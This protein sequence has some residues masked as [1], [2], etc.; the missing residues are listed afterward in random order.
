MFQILDESSLN[1]FTLTLNGEPLTRSGV[2][3][4]YLSFLIE[5]TDA[6]DVDIAVTMKDRYGNESMEEFTFTVTEEKVQLFAASADFDARLDA[7]YLMNMGETQNTTDI[8]EVFGDSTH[9]VNLSWDLNAETFL[10]AGP[11]SLELY[12]GLKD[13]VAAQD[14]LDSY[15]N[16]LIADMQNFLNLYNPIDLTR[17]FDYTG[18]E[19]RVY[20]NDN[21][22]YVRLFLFDPAISYTFGDQT[23]LYQKE[24]IKNM[25]MRGSSLSINLPFLE[26]Q[27]SKGLTDPGLY[28]VAW[29][30]N[31]LGF[32]FAVKAKEAWYLQTNLSII[33]SAQ[34]T[35]DTLKVSG[36]VSQIGTLYDLGSVNPDQNMVFGM[37]TG[38]H[39]NL[40]DLDASFSFSLYND[41]ASSVIDIHNLAEELASF[42]DVTSYAG[43]LDTIQETFP[44]LNYFLPTTGLVSRVLS[45]DLW[46]ITYGVDLS[47]PSFGLEGWIRKTDSTY[48]SL[49]A[50][51]PT[52]EFT[53]GGAFEKWFGGLSLNAGYNFTQDTVLDIL[54]HEIIPLVS[55][56]FVVSPTIT[57]DSIANQVHTATAGI[58]TPRSKIFGGL[59]ID[60]SF[61]FATTN[62]DSLLSQT[63]D[64]EVQTAIENSTANN[65]TTTH[66]TEARWRSGRYRVGDL[67]LS[68]HARTKDSY[69][70]KSRI[71]GVSSNT[72]FWEYAYSLSG[73]FAFRSYALTLGFDTAWSTEEGSGT[74]YGYDARFTISD[75]F[76][77][78]ISVSGSLDQAF[79]TSLD[80][81][82]ITGSLTLE[83]RFSIISTSAVMDIRFF[84][85]LLDDT[86]DSLKTALT[87]K[88]TVS[89]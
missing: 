34:G 8:G 20:G 66:T 17:D 31:F 84:N 76:F 89:R 51:V 1:D 73:L 29:P 27:V 3:R 33:S 16:T 18:E 50:S 9:A 14:I 40:F 39:N 82:E 47:I 10:K 54:M 60:Y 11:V 46:G 69:I 77:D 67:G 53:Y 49:G 78:A 79:G 6:G 58:T 52:D 5:P 41:D 63:S 44:I 2:F 24:T 87:V 83:K 74:E 19:A 42:Y 15:P 68:F 65:I 23:V 38:S 70:L 81:Y 85:S 21:K 26:L 43:Y 25:P 4:E 7:E 48:R 36:A 57:E 86:T 61:E 64:S 56:D 62:S 37:S 88:A 28:Q 13:T 30:E 71:E 45:R 80:A 59:G 55:P 75:T 72:A 32:K 22:G 12:L 35:Y